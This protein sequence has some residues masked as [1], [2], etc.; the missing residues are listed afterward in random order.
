MD[1][2]F[3]VLQSFGVQDDRL[4]LFV[5]FRMIELCCSKVLGSRMQGLGLVGKV[6]SAK[7]QK[8]LFALGDLTHLCPLRGHHLKESTV[9]S[10]A[11]WAAGGENDAFEAR[12]AV[13]KGILNIGIMEKKME[14][15]KDYRDYIGVIWNDI[16]NS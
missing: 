1:P 10:V 12:M 13:A 2:S 8:A 6:C 16:P 14:T 11:T 15:T 7:A 5:G 4:L 9:A 3:V